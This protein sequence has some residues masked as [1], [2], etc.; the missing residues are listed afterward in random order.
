MQERVVLLR[1]AVMDPPTIPFHVRVLE[2][3]PPHSST[4][5]TL[6]FSAQFPA[7]TRV[8][9]ESNASGRY[10]DDIVVPQPSL[11]YLQSELCVQRINDVEE[12][13][14]ICGRPMP[15][16]PLHH[17]LIL[18]RNIVVCENIDLHLVWHKDRIFLKPIP[19]YLLDPDF[20]AVYLVL[21][22]KEEESRRRIIE[23][24]LGLLFSYTALIAYQSD[25]TIAQDTGLLPK[26]VKWESWQQFTAQ[27]LENHCYT[28]IDPR[29]WY[30][31]LRLSRLN[32]VYML[33]KGAIFRM[34]SRVGSHSEYQGFL[35]GNL[36]VVATILGYVVIV[37]TAMQVGFSEDRLR[38]SKSFVDMSFGFT[39]LAIVAPLAAVAL[40]C[41]F[42]MGMVVSNWREAKKYERDRFR[43]MGVD[44][45]WRKRR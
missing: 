24:A 20:W 6:Q 14:W 39:L 37:L 13:L 31:E 19:L 32:A 45:K 7:T 40:V 22:T 1:T 8:R 11:E 26:D 44:A 17:Q 35:Y 29:Y 21:S 38:N 33:R 23:C 43:D 4:H 30:G 5:A 36:A 2:N 25:F 34:Y 18:S 3:N 15:P 16:R 12:W 9:V 10:K 28:S 42:V 41:L 27:L